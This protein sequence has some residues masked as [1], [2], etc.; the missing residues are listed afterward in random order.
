MSFIPTLPIC[1]G[2]RLGKHIFDEMDTTVESYSNVLDSLMQQFRDRVTRDTIVFVY[3]MGKSR[4][5]SL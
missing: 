3:H 2:I 5:K 1:I 4:F